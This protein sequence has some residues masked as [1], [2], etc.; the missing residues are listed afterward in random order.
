[1]N[2]PMKWKLVGKFIPNYQKY[3]NG[4]NKRLKSKIRVL[5]KVFVFMAILL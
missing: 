2:I 5:K 1:M 3:T 4:A